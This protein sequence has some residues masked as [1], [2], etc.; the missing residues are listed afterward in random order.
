MHDLMYFKRINFLH[1]NL[2]FNKGLLLQFV[3]VKIK[4]IVNL[5]KIEHDL[6]M[7]GIHAC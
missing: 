7:Q 1:I 5:P 3:T 4:L 6:V 2:F